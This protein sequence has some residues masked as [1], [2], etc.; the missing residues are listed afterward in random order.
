MNKYFKN[1]VVVGMMTA[2]MSAAAVEIG[3]FSVGYSNGAETRTGG[4]WNGP[5]YG[6]SALGTSGAVEGRVLD[7]VGNY[8]FVPEEASANNSD[9]IIEG[10][11]KVTFSDVFPAVAS[12]SQAGLCFKSGGKVY[13]YGS[14]GWQEFSGVT[15]TE[16]EMVDYQIAVS[17]T[18]HKVTYVLNRHRLSPELPIAADTACLT[19]VRYGGTGFLSD[20]RGYLGKLLTGFVIV[21]R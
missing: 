7:G 3:W 21:V 5:K 11:A 13:G 19:Y 16:G 10:K 14:T 20:F 2:G 6:T 18:K 1:L 8:D 17:V 12:D 15:V 9:T 4:Y